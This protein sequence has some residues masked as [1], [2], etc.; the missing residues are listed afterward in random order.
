MSIRSLSP[1]VRYKLKRVEDVIF[2]SYSKK[3]IG[4]S[5]HLND[6]RSTTEWHSHHARNYMCGLGDWLPLRLTASWLLFDKAH[7][8][9]LRG[10]RYKHT[11]THTRISTQ[12]HIYVHYRR[13][14]RHGRENRSN[15]GSSSSWCMICERTTTEKR[16]DHIDTLTYTSPYIVNIHTVE[17]RLDKRQ[18]QLYLVYVYIEPTNEQ[19]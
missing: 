14:S 11:H 4:V 12:L 8:I 9:Q 15:S 16:D 3:N 7:S 19:Y 1:R 13:I 2:V 17:Y 6:L 10:Y 5:N 18:W